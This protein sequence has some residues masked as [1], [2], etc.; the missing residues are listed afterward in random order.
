MDPHSRRLLEAYDAREQGGVER[1]VLAL[2]A[3]GELAHWRPVAEELVAR[4]WLEPARAPDT[5]LR[6]EDGRL[7]LAGPLDVTLYTRPGCHLCDE[8]KA[9]ISPLLRRAGARLRQV[10]ID[11]DPALRTRYSLDVPVIFLGARKVAKLR[12]DLEQF[13]RQLDEARSSGLA[14]STDDQT[15]G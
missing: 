3:L 8:A 13:R 2:G 4:G 9:Q 7:A 14:R 10:N 1:S 15:R 5:Y 6:T 11:A 12:V